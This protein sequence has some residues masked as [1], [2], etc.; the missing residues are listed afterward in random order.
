MKNHSGFFYEVDFA[1]SIEFKTTQSPKNYH[2]IAQTH[3]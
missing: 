3:K 1:Q 2:C